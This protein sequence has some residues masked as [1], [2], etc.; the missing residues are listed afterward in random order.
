MFRILLYHM[1]YASVR[2]DDE[3]KNVHAAGAVTDVEPV[4]EKLNKLRVW[5]KRG[6][7]APH[8]PL[9]VLYA[10]GQFSQGKERLCYS[11][12]DK[13]LQSLLSEFGLGQSRG[14]EHPFWRL[15]NDG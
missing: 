5:K 14:T 11:D 4:L 7:V 3:R 6:K 8:K 1:R 2:L 13:P 15:Q 12:V 9:L 10:L